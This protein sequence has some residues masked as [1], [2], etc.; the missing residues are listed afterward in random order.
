MGQEQSLAARN[1]RQR[2]LARTSLHRFVEALVKPSKA[3][4]AVLV[5]CILCVTPASVF[6]QSP[7]ATHTYDDTGRLTQAAALQVTLECGALAIARPT[8]RCEPAD[9]RL[10]GGLTS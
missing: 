9:A 7:S 4:A 1:A 2:I 3:A 6:A 5:A 8:L 10:G